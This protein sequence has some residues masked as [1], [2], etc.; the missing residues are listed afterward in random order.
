ME[1]L[2]SDLAEDLRPRLCELLGNDSLLYH[3]LVRAFES[4]RDADVNA[5]L[6]S[7]RMYPRETQHAV[8]EIVLEWLL[9][10]HE[11]CLPADRYGKP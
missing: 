2:C 11:R 7:L 9:A 10:F 5:A 8:E 3:R 4:D 6:S 1:A